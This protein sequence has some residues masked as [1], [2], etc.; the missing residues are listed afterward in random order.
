MIAFFSDECVYRITTETLR[1]R[2]YPVTTAQEVGLAGQEDQMVL[3][4]AAQAGRV[5]ITNDMHFASILTFPPSRFHG[6][7]VLKIRPRNQDLVHSVLLGYLAGLSQSDLDGT[8]T[9]VDAQK[10]RVRRG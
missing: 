1:Q 8:L 4:A 6:I 7:I 5:F 3:N 2:G 9:I 10:Y